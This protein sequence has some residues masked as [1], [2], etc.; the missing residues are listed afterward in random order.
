MSGLSGHIRFLGRGYATRFSEVISRVKELRRAILPNM[1]ESTLDSG[2]LDRRWRLLEKMELAQQLSLYPPRYVASK[3][4][5][6]RILETVGR[7]Q[8]HLTGIPKPH[9]PTKAVIEVGDPIAVSGKRDR[10]A[11]SDPILVEL[12]ESLTSMLGSLSDEC[13]RYEPPSGRGEG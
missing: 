13:G 12:E 1:I 4:T 10:D 6:D 7:L 11:I 9:F 5:V 2:E 3:P 8:E